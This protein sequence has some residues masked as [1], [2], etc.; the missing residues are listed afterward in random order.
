MDTHF[1]VVIFLL[2]AVSNDAFLKNL[3]IRAGLDAASLENCSCCVN[4][5][6]LSVLRSGMCKNACGSI[7]IIG[8]KENG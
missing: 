3:T 1:F 6:V 4:S 7:F 5:R 8:T 2:K